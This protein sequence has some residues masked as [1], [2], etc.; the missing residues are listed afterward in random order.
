ME[1]RKLKA[2]ISGGK[3]LYGVWIEDVKG[4]FSD[5]ET[6]EQTKRNLQEAI[7]LHIQ[8]EDEADIPEALR[9][10]YEIEYTFDISGFLKYYSTFISFAA[11]KEITGIAQKQL[12][13]YANG[14]RS[15]KKETSEKIINGVNAFC[16]ELSQVQFR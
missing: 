4:I 15:P 1:K 10:E 13:S 14:Y 5:G 9:G 8:G 12:W 11:M 2:V 16:K 3:D 6:L 7:Q